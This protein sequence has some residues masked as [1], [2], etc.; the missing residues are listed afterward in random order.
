MYNVNSKRLL[1][2]YNPGPLRTGKGREGNKYTIQQK[3]K[4]LFPFYQKRLIRKFLLQFLD[5]SFF[6]SYFFFTNVIDK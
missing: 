1:F 4:L 5:Q 3:K 6:L 2:R